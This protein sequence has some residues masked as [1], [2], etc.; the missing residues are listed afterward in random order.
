M[1]VYIK[2]VDTTIYKGIEVNKDS[3]LEWKREDGKKHQ[4]LENFEFIQE[5][6]IE[7]EQ[8]SQEIKTTIHLKEGDIVLFEDE[9]RGY[10]VPVDKFVTIGEAIEDLDCIK[11]LDKEE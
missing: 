2:S 1:K 3:K 4:V 6:K 7:K 8:Y 9:E 10:V 5:E 11:D